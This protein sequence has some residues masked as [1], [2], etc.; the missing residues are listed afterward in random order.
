MP[1]IKLG[2]NAVKGVAVPVAV[3]T[4]TKKVNEKFGLLDVQQ[5]QANNPEG[6]ILSQEIIDRMKAET[7]LNELIAEGLVVLENEEE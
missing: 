5:F 3:P 1:N 4:V 6:L 2:E 7:N